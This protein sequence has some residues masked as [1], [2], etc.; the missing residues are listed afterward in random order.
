MKSRRLNR[1]QNRSQS[2]NT[3]ESLGDKWVFV[4]SSTKFRKES[5][6]GW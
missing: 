3:L 1:I 4:P 5:N 2:S 6:L